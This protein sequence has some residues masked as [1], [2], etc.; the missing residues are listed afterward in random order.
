MKKQVLFIHSAGVQGLH[1][2]SNDLIGYL[3]EMLGDEYNLLI[4]KMPNPEN[5]EYTLWKGQL[6]VVFAELEGEII[7][8]GHSLGGSVLLKYLSEKALKQSI[9]GL[10][11]IASPFWG[12]DDDWQVEEYLLPD[13]FASNFSQK[14]EMFFYHSCDDEIVHLHTLDTTK[15][16]FHRQLPEHLM[17]M[18]IT[19]LMD[20][21]NL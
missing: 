4:P 19:S 5:P 8:I 18:N 3:K 9:S 6:N 21:L 16:S 13:N 1:Q 20:C 17:V 7:L 2:G 11:M 14:S 15:K 10:F 12:K